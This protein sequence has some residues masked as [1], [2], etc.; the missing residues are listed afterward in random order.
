MTVNDTIRGNEYTKL[1]TEMLKYICEV[2]PEKPLNVRSKNLSNKYSCN[3]NIK[4]RKNFDSFL[5]LIE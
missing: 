5:C 2:R 1:I 3:L 4:Q